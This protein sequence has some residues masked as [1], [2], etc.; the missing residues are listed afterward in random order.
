MWE[1]IR[2]SS[3]FTNYDA[4]GNPTDW[5][6]PIYGSDGVVLMYTSSSDFNFAD[7]EFESEAKSWIN[8]YETRTSLNLTDKVYENCAALPVS[9]EPL[10]SFL[11]NVNAAVDLTNTMAG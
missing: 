5:L 10:S 6:K 3:V 9:S 11:P 2:V 8:L 4:Q 1:G 7:Y